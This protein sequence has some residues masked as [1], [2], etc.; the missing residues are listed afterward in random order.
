MNPNKEPFTKDLLEIL[1]KAEL[2]KDELDKR[3]KGHD[4]FSG[5]LTEV[6]VGVTLLMIN[7]M[8]LL[9]LGTVVLSNPVLLT[10]FV[11]SGLL[12]TYYPKITASIQRHNLYRNYSVISEHV[13]HVIEIAKEINKSD[14]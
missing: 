13:D 9:L 12:G 2:L 3:A 6:S 11:T 4:I 1:Q 5:I 7:K 10:I 14:K 8:S